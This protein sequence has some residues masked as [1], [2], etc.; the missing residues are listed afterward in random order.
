MILSGPLLKKR[1]NNKVIIR[2]VEQYCVFIAAL[3][4]TGISHMTKVTAGDCTDDCVFFYGI[5]LT[6]SCHA[7]AQL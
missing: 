6:K 4:H 1:R 7:L 3:A 5:R 2:L